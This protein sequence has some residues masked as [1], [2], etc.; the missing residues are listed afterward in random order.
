MEKQL[1]IIKEIV[2]G[3]SKENEKVLKLYFIL[4]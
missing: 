3:F 4:K 1:F 2:L